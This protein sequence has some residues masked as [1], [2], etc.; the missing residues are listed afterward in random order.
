VT[1]AFSHLVVDFLGVPAAQLR[2]AALIG[3]LLIAAVSAAGLVAR[4]APVVRTMTS[5]GVAGMFLLEGGHV[6]VHTFP[7]D[8]VLLLDVLHP[9]AQAA[10]KALDVFAHRLTSREIRSD[11]RARG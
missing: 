4:G 6:M 2:D 3:G 11:Q 5:D 8:E 1:A 10:G 7:A 9:A